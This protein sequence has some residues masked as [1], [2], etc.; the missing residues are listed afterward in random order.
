M[1][2]MI[3]DV[4]FTVFGRVKIDLERAQQDPWWETTTRGLDFNDPA[5]LQQ[6]ISNYL[7]A[8][9]R[10]ENLLS[11]APFTCGPADVYNTQIEVKSGR[12][13]TD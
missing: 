4:A 6:A 5:Q 3:L 2:E 1:E 8:Y 7:S 13:T 11:D 12:S 9:L 10:H